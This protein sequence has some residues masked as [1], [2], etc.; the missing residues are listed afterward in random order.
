MKRVY[1]K[2]KY[3]FL[4]TVDALRADH[5][6]CIGGGNLTPNIDKIAKESLLFT[7]AFANGPG[8]NQSFPALM[9]STYFY[10][11]NGFYLSPNYDT[12]SEIMKKNGFKTAIISSGI[13]IL[14]D[15]VKNMLGIDYSYANRLSVDHDGWLTGECEEVVELLRKDLI[16]NN[17]LADQRVDANQCIVI[18]DT[19][20]DIS[21]FEQAGLSIAFNPKDEDVKKA[22]D[23]VINHKDLCQIM[24]WL[25]D[26]FMNANFALKFKSS[27]L[28]TMIMRSIS[29]D[30]YTLPL[31]LSLRTWSEG[32][33]VYVKIFC[34]KGA[35]TLLATLDDLFACM[36][37]AE[38]TIDAVSLF[39]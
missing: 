2:P 29:P 10:M 27:K 24:P 21:L 1:K 6:G 12:L 8:T 28:A 26:E 4:I 32:K 22:A 7:R 14:A 23:L 38:E 34:T 20:F 36:Q 9:T 17:L 13:S 33:I 5:V 30:N 16:L 3:V 39:R 18:G 37:V 35:T 11:H 25:N 19:K 31:G 15:R